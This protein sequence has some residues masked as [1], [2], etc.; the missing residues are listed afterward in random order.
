M[1]SFTQRME[2]VFSLT[3]GE[4]KNEQNLTVWQRRFQ[5]AF[6]FCYYYLE[7][8]WERFTPFFHPLFA[9]QLIHHAITTIELCS[10]CVLEPNSLDFENDLRIC[11]KRDSLSN[12]CL[13][14]EPIQVKDIKRLEVYR[15]T[16]SSLYYVAQLLPFAVPVIYAIYYMRKKDE[17]LKFDERIFGATQ[18]ISIVVTLYVCLMPFLLAMHTELNKNI[19]GKEEIFKGQI[20]A[21]WLIHT[22]LF[23]IMFV[24]FFRLVAIDM[25]FFQFIDWF[26]EQFDNYEDEE[27]MQ[28]ETEI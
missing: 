24:L 15:L 2:F 26:L 4:M 8:E 5:T 3:E 23:R 1:E 11:K 19:Q 21:I 10:V 13:Q 27:V 20:D 25:T 16:I 17:Q 14:T 12:E 28:A 9:A 22:N 18:L 7:L 6:Y